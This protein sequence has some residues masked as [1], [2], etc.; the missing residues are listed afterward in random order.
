MWQESWRVCMRRVSLCYSIA[1]KKIR[2]MPLISAPL[3]QTK[4]HIVSKSRA[5]PGTTAVAGVPGG[6]A[7]PAAT[8]APTWGKGWRQ[9]VVQIFRYQL[10]YTTSVRSRESS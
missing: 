3:T 5:E 2:F 7:S 8:G 10:C 1:P 4:Q 9:Y 6:A